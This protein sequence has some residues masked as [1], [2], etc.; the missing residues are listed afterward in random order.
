M[1]QGYADLK[2]TDCNGSSSRSPTEMN[3]GG[4][5]DNRRLIEGD[6]TNSAGHLIY[7][8]SRRNFAVNV[9]PGLKKSVYLG[10]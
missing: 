6:E 2:K 3:G 7:P 9:T 4:D 5:G 1:G 8:G 10:R